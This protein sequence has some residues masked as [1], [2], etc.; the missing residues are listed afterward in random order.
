MR[1]LRSIAFG[2]GGCLL[3]ACSGSTGGSLPAS[4]ATADL[5]QIEALPACGSLTAAE[6]SAIVIGNVDG[7][8]RGFADLTRFADASKVLRAATGSS[9][10]EPLVDRAALD[11]DIDKIT[12]ELTEKFFAP[13]NVESA[14]GATV[15]YLLRPEN[16]CPDPDP[17]LD[18]YSYQDA[19]AE[20]ADCVTD[21][22]DNPARLVVTRVKCTEDEN[23]R[24]DVLYG[25]N[26]NTLAVMLLTPHALQVGLDV[27]QY[28]K[29]AAESAPA[30][31]DF[32]VSRAQ[33]KATL[34]FVLEGA[35]KGTVHASVPEN[36]LWESSENGESYA[37]SLS[38]SPVAA[39]LSI[40]ATE[41]V[42]EGNLRLSQFVMTQPFASFVRDMFGREPIGAA[43]FPTTTILAGIE[44][45]IRF[46]ANADRLLATG[47]GLGGS[48]STISAEGAT[49]VS[50]D[51]APSLG[52]RIDAEITTSA[53]GLLLAKVTKG[54]ALQ[55]TYKL[56]PV[57]AHVQDLQ[58]FARNDVVSIDAPAGT[59]ARF[60][61][62][63][64]GDL[65]LQSLPIGPVLAI[66]Q[67]SLSLSSA[68]Y[69][70][71]NLTVEAP[72]CLHQLE[73]VEHGHE[74]IGDMA[75][76]VCQ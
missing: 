56:E 6:A 21:L 32:V 20:Q 2:F 61:R 34:R 22:T 29:L 46:E 75:A 3:S 31:S 11:E 59:V 57:A 44:G 73:L 30:D 66:E 40:D 14:E 42:I 13:S 26:K 28:G 5:E 33:G 76:G 68:S 65:A 60:L 4:D 39:S 37:V 1:L 62:D 35:A 9:S 72:Q 19:L 24:V 8:V 41:K 64:Y 52:R 10:S 51:V 36:V 38:A 74:M 25:Q 12:R 16:M 55:L 70:Q 47:L 48:T 63:E 27:A 43:L 49:L 67:G 45:N 15:S 69:P 18:E 71:A 7:L 58:A 50:I 53:D 54:F 23:V 17:S